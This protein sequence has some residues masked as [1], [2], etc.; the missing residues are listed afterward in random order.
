MSRL[1]FFFGLILTI[2]LS[3]LII[4]PDFEALRFQRTLRADETLSSLRCPTLLTTAQPA[5]IRAS[6]ENTLSRNARFAV[7][8]IISNG[9]P[10]FSTQTDQEIFLDS[11]KSETLSWEVSSDDAA[12]GRMVLARIHVFRNSSIP[13]MQKSCGTYVLPINFLSGRMV[14]A[15]LTIVGV[16]ALLTGA[17]LQLRSADFKLTSGRTRALSV[18][19]V[20]AV[21]LLMLIMGMVG[22]TVPAIFLMVILVVA[23][24]A[25]F[26]QFE[27]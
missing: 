23:L 8:A 13:S 12:Y 11:G 6:I 19:G 20:T 2:G 7:R 18:A 15:L 25:S 5:E 22:Q 4:W 16:G 3:V 14:L 26:A 10:S 27:N 9:E 17:S 24:L 1:L 21:T